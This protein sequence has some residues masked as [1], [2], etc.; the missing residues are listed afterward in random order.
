MMGAGDFP[1]LGR[2]RTREGVGEGR[3]S[4]QTA[5]PGCSAYHNRSLRT[6]SHPLMSPW[7]LI[8]VEAERWEGT[9]ETTTALKD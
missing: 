8:G 4:A 9:A 6:R 2:G 1:K 5:I 3:R 7:E